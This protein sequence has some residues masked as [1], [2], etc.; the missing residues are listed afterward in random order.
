MDRILRKMRQITS[1]HLEL[2]LSPDRVNGTYPVALNIQAREAD[3]ERE[4][5]AQVFTVYVTVTDGKD[6]NAVPPAEIPPSQPKL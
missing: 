5:F 4:R 3:G 6:P 1:V 2:E